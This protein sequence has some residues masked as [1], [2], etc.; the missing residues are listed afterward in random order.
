MQALQKDNP[1]P[2]AFGIGALIN[3]RYHLDAEIGRG[4]MGIVYRAHDIP[5]N[6]DVAV[7]IVNPQKANAL[8][9][10]QFTQ[11]SQIS[12]QL[13]HPHIIAVYETG[14]VDTGAS[15]PWPYIVMEWVHGTGLDELRGFTF[16]RIIDLG[17]Q[18]CEA[19]EYAH[20]QG[21]VHRD[22]KPGNVLIEKH[23]F[24]MFAKLADFGLAR[25]LGVENLPT[26]SDSAGT[27]FYLA[28][29]V[30][31][32]QPADIRSDLY[33]LGA[34]L[35]EML[36][37]RVP[38]SD[39]DDRAVLTQ[40]LLEPVAPPSHARADIPPALEA[41]IL[42]LLAKNPT[43]RFDSARQVSQAL[44]QV[45]LTIDPQTA[46]GNLPQPIP[47][48]AANQA[49]IAQIKELL[50]SNRLVTV[51]TDRANLALSAAAQLADQ[52]PDGVWLLELETLR[53]AALLLPSAASLLGVTQDSP[54]P[55]TVLL[56]EHLRE[57]NILL[58]LSH[59][60][61]LLSAC[62]QLIETILPTCPEV[63][64]LAISRQPIMVPGAARA[65]F[66]PKSTIL[67]SDSASSS[68]AKKDIR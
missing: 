12:A 55:L 49:E 50:A 30:I 57:K 16:A 22:L 67:H 52:F 41:I 48:I 46:L 56:I 42:R 1:A 65:I 60:D 10:G 18:I 21:F 64:I 17:Q 40:H 58:L 27:I 54:R 62:A 31:A 61:H 38:F 45:L 44:Q 47:P 39:Y 15:Q 28:P 59:C 68:T 19:L 25:P 20:N 33:A 14:T 2:T 35:Y 4:G 13:K 24:Q 29:E 37:G 32:G 34:L 9:L 43:D 8:T 7:K 26:E 51:P 6:R 11:E 3:G 53:E 66:P 36:T 23:G 63:H 5:N